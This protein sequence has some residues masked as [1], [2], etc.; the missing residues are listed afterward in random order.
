MVN[1]TDWTN[2][3]VKVTTAMPSLDAHM[4]QSFDQ[5][6]LEPPPCPHENEKTNSAT[7]C[8]RQSPQIEKQAKPMEGSMYW[9]VVAKGMQIPANFRSYLK[10]NFLSMK[11]DPHQL[12]LVSASTVSKVTVLDSLVEVADNKQ[13]WLMVEKRLHLP[14]HMKRGEKVAY[15]SP[16]D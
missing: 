5:G 7:F 13:Q 16:L 12:L 8:E 9:L 10:C 4:Q 14:A 2:P 1:Q 15:V 3:S 6:G 11:V